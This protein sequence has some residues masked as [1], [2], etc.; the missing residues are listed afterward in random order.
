LTRTA[1]A[2]NWRKKEP[3]GMMP[4]GQDAL[5]FRKEER[6]AGSLPRPEKDD[7]PRTAPS[8]IRTLP[9]ASEFHRIMLAQILSSLAGCTAG[10]DLAVIARRPHRNPEGCAGSMVTKGK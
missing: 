2:W 10:R 4:S 7:L 6:K 9:S 1:F 5:H 3:D 8:S